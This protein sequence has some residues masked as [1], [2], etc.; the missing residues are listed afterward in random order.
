MKVLNALRVADVIVLASP[1][2]FYSICAQMKALIDRCLAGLSVD[3]GQDVL[4]DR[5]GGRPA[6]HR[7]R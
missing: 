3:Q 6:A 1:V 7:C 2:Y 5:Y 4:P